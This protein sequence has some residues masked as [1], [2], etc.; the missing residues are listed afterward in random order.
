MKQTCLLLDDVGFTPKGRFGK[1]FVIDVLGWFLLAGALFSDMFQNLTIQEVVPNLASTLEVNLD[2]IFDEI[3]QGEELSETSSASSRTSASSSSTP[4]KDSTSL[5]HAKK[6]KRRNRTTN[7]PSF[8]PAIR[9]FRRDI[10]RKY[11]EMLNNVLNSYDVNLLR[12]FLQDFAVPHVI[13]YIKEFPSDL[14]AQLH[15][16]TKFQGIEAAVEALGRHYF[17][18][19]DINFN[20]SEVKVCQR[21]DTVGSRVLISSLIK[22]TLVYGLVP[23]IEG[24]A[25]LPVNEEV[26]L[27]DSKSLYCF[28]AS[29]QNDNMLLRLLEQQVDYCLQVFLTISLDEQH[30]FVSVD[31]EASR[32]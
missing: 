23:R 5:V 14:F 25:S 20:F 19:P 18:I 22:G 1:G 12:R 15:N 11:G 17:A 10:R 13:Q 26:A 27:V 21:L 32:A 24:T 7:N 9:I 29:Q 4:S 28:D 3:L 31:V 30:R 16:T 6:R 8:I 2:R